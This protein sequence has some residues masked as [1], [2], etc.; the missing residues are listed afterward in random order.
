MAT[1]Q[2]IL[3]IDDEFDIREVERLA[4]MTAGYEVDTA[5][6]GKEGLEKYGFGDN[7]DLV[8]LDQRMPGMQGVEVLQRIRAQNSSAKVVMVTAHASIELV[9]EVMKSGATDFLRKPFDVDILF[10]TVKAALEQPHHSGTTV[11][12]EPGFHTLNGFQFRLAP[13]QE[14]PEPEA[15]PEATGGD[16]WPLRRLYEV[17]DPAGEA[18]Y[19]T[20]DVTPF[21]KGLFQEATGDHPD[22]DPLWNTVC[23]SALANYLWQE[24]KLPPEVLHVSD[25]T[26]QQLQVARHL[27]GFGPPLGQREPSDF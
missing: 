16:E 22:N 20:V 6:D 17:R 27:A 14:L 1:K 18:M 23:E 13:S 9:A 12:P 15:R 19:C 3:I 21:V 24:A 25:L 7:W 8:L 4:L 11:F 10:G 5:A 2:R 26:G